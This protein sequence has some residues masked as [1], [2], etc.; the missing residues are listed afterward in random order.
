MHWRLAVLAILVGCVSRIERKVSATAATIDHKAPFLKVHMRDGDMF[1]LSSWSVD[2]QRRVV[3]GRGDQL[4]ADRITVAGN[5]NRTIPL[6]DVALFETNTIVT[7]PSV[8]AMA[9]VTG[10]SVVVTVA[11]LTNPKACFGSCPTFY[12]PGEDGQPV[13]QAE[14]FSDAIAPSLETHDI[15]ALWRTHTNGGRLTLKMTNEAYET[16]V[17]KGANLLVVPKPPGGRV[18]STGD[19]LWLASSVIAPSRCEAPEGSCLD[20]LRAVDGD[21]R[22]SLT[23]EHDLAARETIELTFPATPGRLGVVVGARQSL[24]TTFLLYQG[25]SYLG[26]TA[27]AWLAAMERGDGA[28]AGGRKLQKLIG[29]IEVQAERDDGWQTVGEAYETGPLAT[30]VHLIVLPEGASGEHVRLRLPR[31]GWRVDYA[32]LATLDRA[33]TPIVV[34]PSR[35]HGTLGRDYAAARQ[36]A[37]DFPIVTM[38]GDSYDLDYD[39]PAGGDYEVFLDSHGY[40]LEWMRTEWM[41]EQDPLAALRMMMDPA[42]ALRDLAPAFKKME[43]QAEQLFWRSRY[44]HP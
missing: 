41:R 44:A 19:R 3:I 13:L 36:P 18:L 9:I 24:V 1:V 10:A 28:R 2:E 6:S 7:S 37:T 23:D 29:G 25:L 11:C 20:K 5:P 40:Y 33:V 31:G 42:K 22:T 32:A 21:E 8:A 39:I 26:D 14:G 30:D 15:D 34:A 17:V 35:V 27:G 16:H 43:P 4:G 38:P 12:A